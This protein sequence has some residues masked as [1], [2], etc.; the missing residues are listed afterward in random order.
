MSS[1]SDFRLPLLTIAA[2]RA[3]GALW[4]PPD[5]LAVGRHARQVMPQRLNKRDLMAAR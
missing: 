1:R 3:N 5:E 2:E 4:P